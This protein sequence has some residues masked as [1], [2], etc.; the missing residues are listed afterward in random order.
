MK[1]P[2]ISE[3]INQLFSQHNFE[4]CEEASDAESLSWG[5][6]KQDFK[7][8]V[9]FDLTDQTLFLHLDRPFYGWTEDHVALTLGELAGLVSAF[10]EKVNTLLI[11][12]SQ[13]PQLTKEDCELFLKT[14]SYDGLSSG[15]IEYQGSLY[16][17]E[18]ITNP[19]QKDRSQADQARRVWRHFYVFPL[20][21]EE[22]E[23]VVM[24]SLDWMRRINLSSLCKD[25][26]SLRI[27]TG[28][29]AEHRKYFDGPY[30]A[31]ITPTLAPTM[32]LTWFY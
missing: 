16:Y 11:K 32:K 27:E 17:I 22:L 9:S 6:I 25:W 15:V 19:Y 3:T 31:H 14:G 24:S 1:S 8:E 10:L 28:P 2:N 21:K 12:D 29:E 13:L 7:V 20:T 4:L 26:E 23:K 5:W 18:S 30:N